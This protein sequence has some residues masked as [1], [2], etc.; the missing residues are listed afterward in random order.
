MLNTFLKSIASLQFIL[1]FNVLRTNSVKD[2]SRHT[3]I[4]LPVSL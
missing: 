1:S 2:I 4:K 3:N